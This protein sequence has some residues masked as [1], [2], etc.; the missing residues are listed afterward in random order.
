M[1]INHDLMAA[2]GRLVETKSYPEDQSYFIWMEPKEKRKKEREREWKS[3]FTGQEVQDIRLAWGRVCTG[4]ERRYLVCR[5]CIGHRILNRWKAVIS[6]TPAQS[7]F[8]C[9]WTSNFITIQYIYIYI[10]IIMPWL[11]KFMT[12]SKGENFGKE[13]YINTERWLLNY[14]RPN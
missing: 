4:V 7:G 6:S 10:V 5:A 13:T 8:T 12:F 11:L 14:R 3:W 2:G 1:A 9:D